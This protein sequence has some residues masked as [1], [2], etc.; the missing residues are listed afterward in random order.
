MVMLKVEVGL[1][2]SIM[3]GGRHSQR[4][5]SGARKCLKNSSIGGYLATLAL[6]VATA[7]FC[8]ATFVSFCVY[9]SPCFAEVFLAVVWI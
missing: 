7:L 4:V 8:V 9:L 6:S 5:V 1:K 2:S 3:E